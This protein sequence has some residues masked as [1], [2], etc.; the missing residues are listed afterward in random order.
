MARL[1]PDVGK[2][3]FIMLGDDIEKNNL[4]RIEHKNGERYG[5]FYA[6]TI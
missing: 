5:N 2:R 3:I 6:F 4:H 1:L